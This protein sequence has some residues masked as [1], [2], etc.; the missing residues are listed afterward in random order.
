MLFR[1]S[2]TSISLCGTLVNNTGKFAELTVSD[3]DGDTGTEGYVWPD[4]TAT[5]TRLLLF[6][7]GVIRPA[8][9]KNNATSSETKFPPGFLLYRCGSM[10]GTEAMFTVYMM[11]DGDGQWGWM[12]DESV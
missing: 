5:E 2:G 11:D 4:K 9:S 12:V 6:S 1:Y 3:D 10:V 8:F 7:G